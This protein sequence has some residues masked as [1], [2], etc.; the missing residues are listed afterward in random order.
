MSVTKNTSIWALIGRCSFSVPVTPTCC[1]PDDG[2]PPPGPPPRPLAEASELDP[3]GALCSFWGSR[4][5]AWARS[6]SQGQAGQWEDS[7]MRVSLR[8]VPEGCAAAGGTTR[9]PSSSFGFWAWVG[10]GAGATA[11][12]GTARQGRVTGMLGREG[13]C[14]PGE[15]LS[16]GWK[17]HCSTSPCRRRGSRGRAGLNGRAG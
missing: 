8:K 17:S 6:G 3:G 12:V 14:V 9:S 15:G 4:P 16:L 7:S 10:T 5:H 1:S 2:A 13:S 11:P